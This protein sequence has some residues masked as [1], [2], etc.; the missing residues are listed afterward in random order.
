MYDESGHL[1]GDYGATGG[2]RSRRP[3]AAVGGDTRHII[4]TLVMTLRQNGS[5][6]DVYYVHTDHLNTPRRVTRPSHIK[7]RWEC[8]YSRRSPRSHGIGRLP[9]GD[10]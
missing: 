9:P 2:V 3:R 4:E 6:V 1:L 10:R 7:K 8:P 5:I